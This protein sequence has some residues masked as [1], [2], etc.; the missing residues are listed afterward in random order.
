MQTTLAGAEAEVQR[1]RELADFLRTRRTRLLPAQVGLPEGSRRRTPGL[2]REE[3]AQ[4]AA[5]GATW[6]TRL[7][8]EWDIRVSPTALEGIAHALRLSPE[9]RRHLF[10]LADQP[11]P[12]APPPLDEVVS[13]AIQYLLDSLSATPA[14]VLGRRYDLLAANAV[15]RQVFALSGLPPHPRNFVWALF[16]DAAQRRSYPLWEAVAQQVLAQF[17]ADSAR[18]PGDPWFTELI[19]DLHRASPEFRAWWPRHDVRGFLDGRK[20]ILHPEVGPLVFQHTTLGIPAN[21]DFKLMLY[22]PLPEADTAAKIRRLCD[23]AT[24]PG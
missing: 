22:V 8:Q 14:Q 3:V 13:A 5:I 17:R 7:E 19:G 10:L 4:L 1:R 18:Y 12:P 16:T 11:L 9:E 6:Y 15:A 21:P 24:L 20:E 2:R 23:A